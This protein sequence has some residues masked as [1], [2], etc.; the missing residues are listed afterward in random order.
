MEDAADL[1]GKAAPNAQSVIERLKAMANEGGEDQD[2]E[3]KLLSH[4][5]EEVFQAPPV[6]DL[7][8]S[9]TFIQKI[10]DNGVTAEDIPDELREEWVRSILG[11]IPFSYK[12]PVL[13][14]RVILVFSEL[15]K[16]AAKFSRRFNTVLGG[17]LDAQI[18]LAVV[19]QLK[20]VEGE[21]QVNLTAPA[22]HLMND[23]TSDLHPS[24]AVN[25]AYD[26]V[27][28]SLP[29]GLTR[30]I[31]GAWNIYSTLVGILTEDAF[32]DSF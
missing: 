3:E 21:M 26:A 22:D 13:G 27:C 20:A 10:R 17:N 18:K 25:K 31:L 23:S 2:R 12:I 30:F 1:A 14:G 15:D 8:K 24:L 29:P 32:P 16:E 5:E 28:D 19:L 11:G 6:K 4:K 7:S 9:K